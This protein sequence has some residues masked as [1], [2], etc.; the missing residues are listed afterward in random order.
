MPQSKFACSL[1]RMDS[2]SAGGGSQDA[3]ENRANSRSLAGSAVIA[4]TRRARHTPLCARN[5][6]C[7]Y[8]TLH[9]FQS[10][11]IVISASLELSLRRSARAGITIE[12]VEGICDLVCVY[13]G[14]FEAV[15]EQ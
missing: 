9:A 13:D 4:A 7:A 3:A 15:I 8:Q 10:L 2:S 5:V 1:S 12:A 14:V 6:I 11:M